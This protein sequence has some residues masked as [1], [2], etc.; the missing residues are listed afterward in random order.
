MISIAFFNNK[1]GVGKTTLLC[2]LASF[3]AKNRN[4]RVLII[5]A[6]PQSNST[7]YL[8]PEADLDEYFLKYDAINLFAYYETIARGKGLPTNDPFII[9]SERFGVDIVPG[10]P[11]FALRE[12][13]LSKDWGEGLQGLERGLQTTFTFKHLLK[14]VSKNYDYVFIDM[15]PSLG[16]I[17]RSILLAADYF[18]TPMSADL[19]SLLAIENIIV[20]LKTWRNELQDALKNYQ[21]KNGASYVMDGEEIDWKVRYIGFVMQQYKTKSVRGEL[22]PVKSYESLLQKSRPELERLENEFGFSSYETAALGQ[23]PNLYSLIP[24]SQLAHAPIFELGKEDGVV[25]AHFA[26]VDDAKIMYAGIADR[27]ISRVN[28]GEVK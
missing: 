20:S 23:I 18:L 11:K 25:G 17:N 15:G 10:H 28:M 16:A 24:L 19:F 2:N 14:Q 13:L 12:D 27:L 21:H 9:K 7:A 6:D 4:K 3:I 8:I 26:A 22:R 5:D 1:G